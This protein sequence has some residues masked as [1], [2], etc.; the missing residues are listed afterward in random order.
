MNGSLTPLLEAWALAFTLILVRVSTFV[1]VMPLFGGRNLPRMVKIG[2]SV[3]LTVM[4]FGAFA[5]YPTDPMLVMATD[6]HWLA[7]GVAIGREVIFG[8]L[9]GYALGLLLLPARIAGSY[10]AQEMGL[11]LAS[12]SDPTT[13]EQ[14]TVLGQLFESLGILLFF[15]LNIHHVI[16][17][18]LH[19]TFER[20]PIGGPLVNLPLA[21]LPDTVG[22]VHEWGLLI[23]APVGI[24]LFLTVIVLALMMRTAPQ[25][26]LFAIGL[27]L[28]L[29]VGFGAA[30]FFLPEMFG[31][32]RHVFS[33][34]PEMVRWL[35]G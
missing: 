14:V 3:A 8:A 34:A 31:L 29:V 4:W 10:I 24:C 16:L 12:L 23:A 7:F 35:V 2:L 5:A 9:L 22:Q 27:P 1:A 28:R 32:I 17:G 19:L 13:Q 6:I 26:N 30:L 25:L 11:T 18:A 21:A 20:M 15:S 33:H